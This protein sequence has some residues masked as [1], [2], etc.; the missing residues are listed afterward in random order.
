MIPV[1]QHLYEAC[2]EKG[3]PIGLAPNIHVSL[4]LLPEE[5]RAFSSKRYLWQSAKLAV[6]KK[7][8]GRQF[9]RKLREH[10]RSALNA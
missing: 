4:V 5:C 9:E 1:F 3:L 2:M 7:V 10:D 8:F 6:M